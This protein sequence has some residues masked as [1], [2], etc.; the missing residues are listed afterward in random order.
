MSKL[1][2]PKVDPNARPEVEAFLHGFRLAMKAFDLFVLVKQ[3]EDNHLYNL[4]K[5]VAE[6]LYPPFDPPTEP[7]KAP[8]LGY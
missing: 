2:L 5:E 8:K 1:S 4:A 7:V 3:E 6:T